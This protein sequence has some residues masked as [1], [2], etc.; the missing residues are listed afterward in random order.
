MLFNSGAHN[1]INPETIFLYT[2]RIRMTKKKNAIVS[3]PLK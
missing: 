2:P 1:L 3:Y